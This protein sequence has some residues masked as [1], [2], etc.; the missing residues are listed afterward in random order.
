MKRCSSS[1]TPPPY[2]LIILILS[3]LSTRYDKCIDCVETRIALRL[4]EKLGTTKNAN[5]MF[6]IFSRLLHFLLPPPPPSSLHFLPPSST[7]YFSSLSPTS[8][9]SYAW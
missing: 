4:R 1:S 5:E 3:L 2:P 9:S 8:S 7:P 6:R